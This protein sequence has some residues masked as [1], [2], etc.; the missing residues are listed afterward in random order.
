MVTPPDLTRQE[1]VIATSFIARFSD[2]TNASPYVSVRVLSYNA[3]TV[4]PSDGIPDNWMI[5]YFGNAN[6]AVWSKS[7]S[8]QRL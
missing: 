1:Q 7:Q 6:P 2:H 8:N 3:D 5:Q 4:S